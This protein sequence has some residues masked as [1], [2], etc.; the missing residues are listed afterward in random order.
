MIKLIIFII[1]LVLVLSFFGYDIQAIVESPVAQK[2][3]EYVKSG[4]VF[5]WK[6]YLSQPLSYF[7]NNIFL[8]LLWSAFTENLER[9]KDGRPT[10]IQEMAPSLEFNN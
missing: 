8:G 9:V 7:W 4:T 6:E 1:I 5:V 10:Q 2:N 3:I